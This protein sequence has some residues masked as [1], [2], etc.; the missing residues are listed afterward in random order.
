MTLDPETE[1]LWRRYL[2]EPEPT[3]D[4]AR[5]LLD[6]LVAE[7]QRLCSGQR[8]DEV[9]LYTPASRTESCAGEDYGAL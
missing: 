6:A 2:G 9:V 3:P 1:S 5:A 8:R 7:W 4:A